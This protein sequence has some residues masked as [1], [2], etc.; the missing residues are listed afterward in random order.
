[1]LEEGKDEDCEIQQCETAAGPIYHRTALYNMVWIWLRWFPLF[2]WFCN[3]DVLNFLPYSARRFTQSISAKTVNKK[4]KSNNSLISL[5]W[6]YNFICIISI[7]I[8]GRK[9]IFSLL[10]TSQTKNDPCCTLPILSFIQKIIFPVFC[11]LSH[12]LHTENA[13]FHL[14]VWFLY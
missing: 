12:L 10:K 1:M 5:E 14:S 11:Y 6:K 3:W 8:I 4:L 13:F 2:Q 7:P 9:I